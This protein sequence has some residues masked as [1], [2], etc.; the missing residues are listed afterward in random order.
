MHSERNGSNYRQFSEASF[1][2]VEQIKRYRALNLSLNEIAQML[3][4]DPHKNC[5]DV[6]ALMRRQLEQIRQQKGLLEQLEGQLEE[7]LQSCSGSGQACS[8]LE[9]FQL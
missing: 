4:W 6:C 5:A 3:S 1:A 9:Q 2:R 7:L 8:I